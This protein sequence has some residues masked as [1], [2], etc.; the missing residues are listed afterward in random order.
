MRKIIDGDS[1]TAKLRAVTKLL[2]AAREPV[3]Q[4]LATLKQNTKEVT[5]GAQLSGMHKFLPGMGDSVEMQ[6]QRVKL[7]EQKKKKDKQ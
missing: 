2:H 3:K 6:L 1:R 4:K 7:D 5:E